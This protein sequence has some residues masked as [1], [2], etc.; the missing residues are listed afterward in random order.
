MTSL[1]PAPYAIF[2]RIAL[3][4]LL[5]CAYTGFVWVK[6]TTHQE[7]VYL[8]AQAKQ[9]ASASRYND[10]Q[11]AA[12]RK[13]AQSYLEEKHRVEIQRDNLG[14]SLAHA[15]G[16]F[17]SL[18]GAVAANSE[19]GPDDRPIPFGDPRSAAIDARFSAAIQHDSQAYAGCYTQ[20]VHLVASCKAGG[21]DKP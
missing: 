18:Q 9:E 5:L 1:I 15:L 6:A 7:N 21:C 20:I 16:M 13:I 10:S 4:L 11:R 12:Q 17:H 2:A 3:Y 14:R 19:S 8:V